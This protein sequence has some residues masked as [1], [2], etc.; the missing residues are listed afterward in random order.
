MD[1]ENHA[2]RGLVSLLRSRSPVKRVA[3]RRDVAGD[4]DAFPRSNLMRAIV[5]PDNRGLWIA[6][7]ATLAILFPTL[8][9]LE[10]AAALMSK[11]RQISRQVAQMRQ[12]NV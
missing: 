6:G 5:N 8:I 4:R 11:Y 2:P 3:S 1:R 7:A 9:R 10:A 12:G